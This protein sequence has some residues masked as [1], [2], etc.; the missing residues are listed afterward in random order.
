MI[1]R[2]PLCRSSCASLLA[3]LPA[4][5]WL[6][7]AALLLG[8]ALTGAPASSATGE[9][10]P[11]TPPVANNGNSTPPLESLRAREGTEIVDQLGHFQNSGDR[12][13]FSTADGKRRYIGLEN[14]NLE[15]IARTI[16]NSPQTLQWGVTGTI[17]EYRGTNFLLIHRAILKSGR[18]SPRG[19][20]LSP[21]GRPPVLTPPQ[22]PL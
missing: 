2:F 12:V 1:P 10:T 17:T 20:P 13:V 16:A 6:S 4:V 11:P 22:P 21:A 7:A 15:R 18:Q 14:L 5:A 3:R 19:Q 8:T 9:H